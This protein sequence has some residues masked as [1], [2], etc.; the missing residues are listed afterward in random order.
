VTGKI[1]IKV[2]DWD[3]LSANDT[4]SHL[5]L[6]APYAPLSDNRPWDDAEY[7]TLVEFDR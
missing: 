1:S 3:A 2:L 6:D 5:E 7:H 4:I